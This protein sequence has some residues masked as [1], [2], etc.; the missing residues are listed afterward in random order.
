VGQQVPLVSS[1]FHGIPRSPKFVPP[2]ASPSAGKFTSAQ[3]F[4][5]SW[6]LNW[7]Q[8]KAQVWKDRGSRFHKKLSSGQHGELSLGG[9]HPQSNRKGRPFFSDWHLVK[10]DIHHL[11]IFFVK[12]RK[13]KSGVHLFK[14]TT[15][16]FV[17][18]IEVSFQDPPSFKKKF[19]DEATWV[20]LYPDL[21]HP[22]KQYILKQ[23]IDPTCVNQLDI[24]YQHGYMFRGHIQSK[25]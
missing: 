18:P 25:P 20:K 15:M 12:R 3:D 9:L 7:S 4:L 17:P 23:L 1:S 6:G 16:P 24:L 21:S 11:D 8:V 22:S 14:K 13:K 10:E 5:S 2:Q 19:W